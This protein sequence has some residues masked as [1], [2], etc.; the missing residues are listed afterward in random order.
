[1]PAKF[2]NKC[3][4]TKEQQTKVVIVR[5]TDML[6]YTSTGCMSNVCSMRTRCGHALSSSYCSYIYTLYS[7]FLIINGS[8]LCKLSFRDPSFTSNRVFQEAPFGVHKA[9]ALHCYL[10]PEC[11]DNVRYATAFLGSYKHV[12][13]HNIL[14]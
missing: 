3:W 14:M 10:S 7:W 2:E 11:G 1:M 8:S 5:S 13:S 12:Q 9:F 6:Q 4:I